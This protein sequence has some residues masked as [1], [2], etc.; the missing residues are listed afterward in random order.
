MLEQ[1]RKFS[2]ACD[3]FWYMSVAGFRRLLEFGVLEHLLPRLE[4]DTAKPCAA[5]EVLLS[6]SSVDNFAHAPLLVSHGIIDR[7]GNLLRNRRSIDIVRGKAC[8]VLTAVLGGGSSVAVDIAMQDG[9][10][11]VLVAFASRN[12]AYRGIAAKV[13]ICMCLRGTEAHRRAL[14]VGGALPLFTKLMQHMPLTVDPKRPKDRVVGDLSFLMLLLHETRQ[15]LR[16]AKVLDAEAAAAVPLAAASSATKACCVPRAE[17]ER[18]LEHW[19][20]EV[21]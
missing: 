19:H 5:L 13:L 15:L 4:A 12:N 6:L 20:Q 8:E 1:D 21:R 2:Y 16:T 10:I 18:L 3:A 7:L 17:L 14:V 11:P 9:L